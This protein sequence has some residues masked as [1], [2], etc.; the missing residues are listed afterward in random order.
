MRH[1]LLKP[2]GGDGS[3]GRNVLGGPELEGLDLAEVL[4][5]S[6]ENEVFESFGV[7][8]TS[9]WDLQSPFS[10]PVPE[11]ASETPSVQPC[12]C[13]CQHVNL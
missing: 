9:L 12:C 13:I 1:S 6:A 10:F 2:V 8:V 4:P 5:F 3:A 7:G 11:S